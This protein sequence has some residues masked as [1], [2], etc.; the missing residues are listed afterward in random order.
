MDIKTEL[1]NNVKRIHKSAEMV[2]SSE[3]YTSACILYF[4]ALFIVLD[5]I[6][7]ISGKELPKDHTQRFRILEKSFPAMYGVL[8]KIYPIYK[9]SYST[10]IS[11]K[12]CDEA[13]AYVN[14]LIKEYKI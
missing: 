4:K 13:R 12:N 10:S 2:Y 7:L 6:I 9:N 14:R 1:L 11:K 3:D 8:D 5:Y